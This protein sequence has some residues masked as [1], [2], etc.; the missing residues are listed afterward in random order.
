MLQQEVKSAKLRTRN[1]E[2]TYKKIKRD[3]EA[4]T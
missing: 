4:V 3:L 1:I 2:E